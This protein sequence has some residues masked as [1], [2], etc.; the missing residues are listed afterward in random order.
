MI[1]CRGSARRA[2]ES[3]I[4]TAV[5]STNS[6]S[7]TAGNSSQVHIGSTPKARMKMKTT[8]RLRPRLKSAGEHDRE[9]DHQARELRLADDPLLG[10]DRGHRGRRRL[11][12][13][14]EEDDVEQQ[15][16]RIVGD[17]GAE[18]ED[19][20]E[21]E[22]QDAEQHQRPQQRPEVAEHGAEVRAL[23]LGHRDQP[24][25]LD[26][27]APAAAERRGAADLAQLERVRRGAHRALLIRR[28]ARPR[29][30]CRPRP[31]VVA[32]AEDDE[33]ERSAARRSAA[34]RASD[35]DAPSSWTQ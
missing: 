6:G 18:P 35:C 28:S 33:V 16:D 11:L 24:E 26:E 21:D 22:E 14:A 7:R 32:G 30:R 5:V 15:Q 1:A 17:V 27:A 34:R 9:R 31:T 10:H 20:R 4:E 25:Q 19:L 12:E 23:E 2:T 8:T 3:S 13:E 29:P